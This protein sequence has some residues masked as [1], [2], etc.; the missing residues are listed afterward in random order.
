MNKKARWLIL[1]LPLFFFS[2]CAVNPLTG[3]KQFM[4][5]SEEQDAEIGRK[6]APEIEKQMGGRIESRKLQNY[7]NRIG[8]G[9]A[10]RS[11]DRPFEYRFAALNDETINAF[12]LPGGYIFITKGML[13]KLGT[14]AQLAGILGHEISHVVTRDTAVL[15]SRE[16][17]INLLLSVVTTE[18]TS[19]GVLMATDITRQILGLRYSRKQEHVADI[20]GMKYMVAAGYSPYGMVE[21]MR[22]LEQEQKSRPIE[23]LSS[24]PPPENR[25]EYLMERIQEDYFNTAGLKVGKEEY[26][27]N[28]LDELYD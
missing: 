28:V 9:I 7:I 2:G 10:R 18:Q 11:H 25:L 5:L 26:A 16:I 14:E 13:Q 24:H 15:M 22:M 20:G 3:E 17:G 19:Q 8:Q 21:T 12:A 27:R 4:L 23:F 6:Y 1:F